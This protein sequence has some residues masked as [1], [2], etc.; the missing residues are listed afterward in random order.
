ML[1]EFELYHNAA[2]ATKNICGVKGESTFDHSTVIKYFKKFC[3][4]CKIL[5]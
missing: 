5:K 4:G 3:L 2:K 1:Y